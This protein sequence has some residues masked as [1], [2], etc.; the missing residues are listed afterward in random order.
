MSDNHLKYHYSITCSTTD[1]T[2]LHCLRSIAQYVEQSEYPQISWGGTTRES[3]KKNNNQFT[4]RFTDSIYRDKF[5]T[6]STRLLSG[7]WSQV[8]INDNDPASPQR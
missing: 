3:W 5:T 6:E 7:H 1:A 4:L 2:V 8:S